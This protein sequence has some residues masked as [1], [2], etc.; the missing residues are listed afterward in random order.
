MLGECHILLHDFF[1]ESQFSDMWLWQHDPTKGYAV[2]G[3]YQILTSHLSHPLDAVAELIWHKQVNFLEGVYFCLETVARQVANKNKF[4]DPWY[5]YSRGP[6]L[7]GRMR[8]HGVRSALIYFLEHL[9][10]SLIVG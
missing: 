9:C 8:R 4:G 3:A 2:Q 6:I 10:L 5:P 1:L 7:C